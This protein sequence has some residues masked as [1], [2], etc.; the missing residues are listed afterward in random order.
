MTQDLRDKL[1]KYDENRY[2]V[3]KPWHC[4]AIAKHQVY[5]YTYTKVAEQMGKSAT[6]LSDVVKS[7]AGRAYAK[8]IMEQM[9]PKM[10]VQNMLET[11]LLS[12]YLDWQQAWVWAMEN[13]D[14]DSIH[15]M[16]KDIGMKPVL[17]DERA[18]LPT[19]VVI[20]LGSE[21]MDSKPVLTSY[22]IIDD[23]DDEDDY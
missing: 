18:Q 12:K 7:P 20:N 17:G 10:M 9:E 21:D 2:E 1:A 19:K 13:R 4:F 11:D 6:T 8:G 15:R 16:A 5:G 3:L 23:D 22:E 14:Y